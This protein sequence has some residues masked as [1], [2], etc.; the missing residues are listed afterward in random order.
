MVIFKLKSIPSP[1]QEGIFLINFLQN[2]SC[3]NRMFAISGN[4]S[5]A[6]CRRLK[7]SMTEARKKGA[8]EC[9]N[10]TRGSFSAPR[11]P[12][13]GSRPPPEFE[14]WPVGQP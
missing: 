14:V 10:V 5:F 11:G 1:K 12:V 8:D 6:R 4:T 2:Y 3:K 9:Q 13:S 7:P